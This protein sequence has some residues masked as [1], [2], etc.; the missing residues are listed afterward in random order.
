MDIILF[1]HAQKGLTPFEDPHLSPEGFRQ[2]ENIASLIEQNKLPKPTEIWVSEKIRTAQ[3][4]QKVSDLVKVE[5]SIRPQLN[6]RSEFETQS[7]FTQ[8][9][10]KEI[11]QL[12]VTIENDSDSKSL[13][14]CTHYDWVEEAMR[15]IPS[16]TD[17]TTFEFSHWGPAHYVHFSIENGTWI[18]RRKGHQ[19]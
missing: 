3:T 2:A 13:F 19:R 5:L 9:V 15:F 1:R 12:A 4:L 14:I 16:N 10:H 11:Q 8:K 7:S 18:V 17:L 6:L